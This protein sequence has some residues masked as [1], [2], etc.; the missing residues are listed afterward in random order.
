MN[1]INLQELDMEWFFKH[2]ERDFEIT[3][4]NAA[5]IRAEMLKE[6]Q[7]KD[8]QEEIHKRNMILTDF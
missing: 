2:H 4:L 5:V 3:P 6:R 1:E 7:L 8:A